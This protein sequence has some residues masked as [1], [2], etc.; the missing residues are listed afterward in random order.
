MVHGVRACLNPPQR[1]L[2][3][4]EWNVILLY[5]LVL[6]GCGKRIDAVPPEKNSTCRK[7]KK[8]CC[9]APFILFGTT[10]RPD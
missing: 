1:A 8:K 9:T 5:E 2:E 4:T 3:R 7:R 10:E 6:I